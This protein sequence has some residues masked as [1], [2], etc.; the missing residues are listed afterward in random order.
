MRAKKNR[1]IQLICVFLLLTGLSGTS[2]ASAEIIG[3]LEDPSEAY[4]DIGPLFDSSE[5]FF[6]EPAMTDNEFIQALVDLAPE[7]G[8][9]V[10]PEGEYELGGIAITKPMEIRGEGK[11]IMRPAKDEE[12]MF[13]HEAPAAD[14]QNFV[15][16]VWSDGV[17]IDGI[18]FDSSFEPGSIDIIHY[19]G[20][21]LKISN[22]VFSVGENG[23]GIMSKAETNKYTIEDNVF[24]AS[25]GRRFFPMIQIGK[26][27]KGA[28]IRNNTLEGGSLD[29]LSD[30]FLANFLTIEADDFELSGN[31]FALIPDSPDAFAF[32]DEMSIPEARMAFAGITTEEMSRLNP[33]NRG[34]QEVKENPNTGDGSKG[35]VLVLAFCLIGMGVLLM[36]LDK[37]KSSADLNQELIGSMNL[38][39]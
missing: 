17:S 11:V 25:P 13:T 30:E 35:A 23:A 28:V 10:I 19:K 7:G 14:Y 9:C 16:A 31:E 24:T 5:L 15:M 39:V 18:K 38:R 21:N 8:T 32:E 29:L 22:N 27:T 4:G 1:R 26:S 6:E 12:D 20:D 37:C 2:L 34:Y 36:V 3:R 33:W